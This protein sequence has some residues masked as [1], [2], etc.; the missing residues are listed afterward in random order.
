[1]AVCP[2]RSAPSSSA[3]PPWSAT[4]RQSV[5]SGSRGAAGVMP[6]VTHFSPPS[7]LGY[8]G[9][10]QHHRCLKPPVPRLAEVFVEW[11]GR[12]GKDV[13]GMQHG[14]GVRCWCVLCAGRCPSVRAAGT[15]WL[16]RSTHLCSRGT[17]RPLRTA[18]SSAMRRSGCTQRGWR[19]LGRVTCSSVMRCGLTPPLGLD[20]H[21]I[22]DT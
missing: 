14:C 2:S 16:T 12:M 8:P 3:Q 21:I 17:A 10:L 4:G 20:A 13:Q 6:M 19:Y 18:S 11:E 15:M 1:L 7:R 9:S 22:C 5:T